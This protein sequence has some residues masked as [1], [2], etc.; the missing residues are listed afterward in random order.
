[1]QLLL[2]QWGKPVDRGAL[3]V[4]MILMLNDE[5][6]T[7]IVQQQPMQSGWPT[8]VQKLDLFLGRMKASEFIQDQDTGT[9]QLIS[10][11]P[12]AAP[13]SRFSD[14]DRQNAEETVRIVSEIGEARVRA[15]FAQVE[16]HAELELVS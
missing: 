5:L 9:R 3:E 11:G 4:G 6:R 12:K 15:Q 16:S 2:R 10:L 1:M 13:L 8:I 14:K 7:A